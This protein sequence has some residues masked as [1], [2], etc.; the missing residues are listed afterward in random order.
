METT[1][2]IDPL[3]Q[4][5]QAYDEALDRVHRGEEWLRSHTTS[6]PQYQQA[7]TLLAARRAELAARRHGLDD[8]AQQFSVAGA[9]EWG[10]DFIHD[11]RGP[12]SINCQVCGQPVHGWPAPQP[13]YYVHLECLDERHDVESH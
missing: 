9:C 10:R 5:Q 8:L 6:H 12:M 2:L 11:R 7:S 13:G 3:E 1:K 4:A